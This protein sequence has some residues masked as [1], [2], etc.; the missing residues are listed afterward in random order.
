[1]NFARG[2]VWAALFTI[3]FWVIVVALIVLLIKP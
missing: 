1:M 2:C 3:P